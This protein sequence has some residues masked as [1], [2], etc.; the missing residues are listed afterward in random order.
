MSSTQ[1][2]EAETSIIQITQPERTTSVTVSQS[3]VSRFPA[4]LRSLDKVSLAD[5]FVRYHDNQLYKCCPTDKGET[6]RLG[7]IKLVVKFMNYF[8]E[9]SRQ[10]AAKPSASVRYAEWYGRLKSDAR[11]FE[12]VVM[13]EL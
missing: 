10:Y 4:D 1:R 9:S 11:D 5:A 3:N 6:D 7:A 8:C 13:E 2:T 12:L